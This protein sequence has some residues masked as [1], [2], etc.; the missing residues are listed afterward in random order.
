MEDPI[1][2]EQLRVTLLKDEVLEE[3]VLNVKD[4]EIALAKKVRLGHFIR[5]TNIYCHWVYIY[6]YIYI[7]VRVI[8]STCHIFS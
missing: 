7:N 2:L 3:G 6:T 8:T 4:F 1:V 5:I